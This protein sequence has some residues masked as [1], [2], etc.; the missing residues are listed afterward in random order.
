MTQQQPDAN[1]PRGA[2][3]VGPE[4][5]SSAAGHAPAQNMFQINVHAV[6]SIPWQ[7]THPLTLGEEA[8]EGVGVAE[9]LGKG[10]AGVAV[11][12]VLVLP[13]TAAQ[14]EAEKQGARIS[15]LIPKEE[16][17]F[18]R[19]SPAYLLKSGPAVVLP[20]AFPLSPSSPY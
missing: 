1:P 18:V 12:R 3:C 10:G 15:N 16:K 5:T 8:L 11:V 9:E 4:G 20:P 7:S 13:G 6:S 17:L 2:E 19:C 14:I